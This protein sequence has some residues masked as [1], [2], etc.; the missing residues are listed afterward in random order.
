MKKLL[1]IGNNLTTHNITTTSIQTLGSFLEQEG[2]VLFYASSKKNKIVRLL[3]MILKTIIYSKKVDYVLIDVYSTLN[4]WYAFI[5]SQLCRLLGLPYI[6]KLHGG[7]LPRRLQQNPW[8]SDLIFK[9]AYKTSAPSLYLL[10]VFEKRYA[11]NLV[12]IPNAIA[13]KNYPFKD[14]SIPFPKLFWLRSLAS[15]YNPKMAIKVL[16]LLKKTYPHAELCMV[17]PDK[18]C[19]LLALK[20]Y[21]KQLN[22]S[23][24]FTGKLSKQDWIELSKD[25][26]IFINTTHYDNTPVSV[27]EAMALGL[28]VVSTNVGGMPFLL[29]DNVDGLLVSDNDAQAMAEAIINLVTFEYFKTALINQARQKVEAFDWEIVKNKWLE[30][31]N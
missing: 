4:F 29:Q 13:L 30:I 19:M 7:D 12:Y 10:S 25:F 15:I 17:G 26:N 27:L 14:R 31:L 5:I 11:A 2:Y 28:P 22:V 1:Y 24:A 21:A 8:M 6:T 18:D 16:S 23:V 3:D 20:D 9:N